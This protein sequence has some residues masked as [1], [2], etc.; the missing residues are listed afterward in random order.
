[1]KELTGPRGRKSVLFE[2]EM[3]LSQWGKWM[4]SMLDSVTDLL[5]AVKAIKTLIWTEETNCWALL[6]EQKGLTV[7]CS[8]ELG[9]ALPLKKGNDHMQIDVASTPKEEESKNTSLLYHFTRI[10]DMFSGAM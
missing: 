8:L 7:R 5:V 1:M 9:T 4:N 3:V 6:Q 2:D 10:R